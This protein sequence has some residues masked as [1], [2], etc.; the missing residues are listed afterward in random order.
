L[1]ILTEAFVEELIIEDVGEH[2]VA[3]G[4]R[5]SFHGSQHYAKAT[6]E[7]IVCTGSVQS[8]QLLEISG[9]GNPSIL[10][11]AGIETK[12]SN[13]NLGENLQDHMSEF[14]CWIFSILLVSLKMNKFDLPNSDDNDL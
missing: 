13:P 1:I 5:F 9:I 3:H 12:F 10:K 8:P 11:T 14:I 2:L 6:K 4:A 7:I